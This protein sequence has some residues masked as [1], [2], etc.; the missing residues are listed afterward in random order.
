MSSFPD[1]SPSRDTSTGEA[2]GALSLI[3]VTVTMKLRNESFNAVEHV[4]LE[5]PASQTLVLVGPSGCGKTTLLNVIAGFLSPTAGKAAIDGVPITGPGADRAVVFQGDAV[6]PWLTVRKNIEYGPRVRGRRN[7]DQTRRN[8]DSFIS[9]MGLESFQNEY[10]KVLSGGMRKR[11]DVAR[12]YV[13][14]PSVILLD[15]PFGALDDMTKT[16]LQEELVNLSVRRPKTTVFVTHDIEEAIYVGDRIAVMTP[17]PA[18]IKRIIDVEY[19]RPR[20]ADLRT[21]PGFQEMRRDIQ[22]LLRV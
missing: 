20:P 11:V 3:D 14:D 21:D 2:R 12:A 7:D 19:S 8:V 16:T 4:T 15:E 13:S 10:P 22:S 5:V 6:F 18:S 1:K 9:L 17:R